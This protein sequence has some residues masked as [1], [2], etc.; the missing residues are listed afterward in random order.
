M[1]GAYQ[2][3]LIDAGTSRRGRRRQTIQ[4]G[5]ISAAAPVLRLREM[6]ERPAA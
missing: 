6:I 5:N 4:L 1:I 3:L 2:D